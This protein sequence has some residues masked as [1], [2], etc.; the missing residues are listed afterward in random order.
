[1]MKFVSTSLAVL[2]AL[3]AA[4]SAVGYVRIPHWLSMQLDSSKETKSKGILSA[5]EDYR[6]A[7]STGKDLV[8]KEQKT[9]LKQAAF[10]LAT[11]YGGAQPGNAAK[12]VGYKAAK[13]AYSP[14]T[15]QYIPP[16]LPQSAL[17]NTLPLDD[18]L[19]GELQAYLESFV[20]LIDPT[21]SEL[22]QIA[23]NTSTLWTNLKVNA[24]RAA[25]MF[26]YNKKGLQPLQ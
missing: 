21:P 22:K 26:L 6:L 24:Q 25:G 5:A 1:M 17:L 20:E 13:S 18:E 14:L 9:L 10:V 19:V 4:I 3:S 2:V 15:P 8:Q 23:S 16:L 7:P 11:I 12:V